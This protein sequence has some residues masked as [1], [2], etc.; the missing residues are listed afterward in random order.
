LT[1]GLRPRLKGQVTAL[2]RPRE[3]SFFVA[4]RALT[5]S[6]STFTGNSAGDGG[7]IYNGNG[8]LTITASTFSGNSAFQG[9]GIANWSGALTVTGST[10][11]GNSANGDGTGGGIENE[12]GTLAI[13]VSTF[14]GNSAGN[15]G[16]GIFN[17]FA[18]LTIAASTVSG[19]S[20]G[21][22]GG[23]IYNFP[24]GGYPPGTV[25]NVRNT[26]L[27][28]NTAKAVGPDVS[29]TLISLG[30]NLIGNGSHGSG[31]ATTDLV[32][33]SANPIDP[34]LGPLQD[35][36]G[37]TWT[38]ALL[39]GSPAIGAGGPGDSEWDQRGPG[40]ARSINGT[41]DIGAYEV[42]P[43]GCG[44]GGLHTPYPRANS[45]VARDSSQ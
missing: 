6:G 5:V 21:S 24:G 42:Q 38:M 44:F 3:S 2:I 28:G 18:T 43:V 26:L 32:G 20:A 45:F 34:E 29:G 16:G 15:D 23:G 1:R 14:S 25:K 31:Y 4:F 10:F 27:A 36:G 40:Y 7:G 33:T 13:T 9:G 35:N 30:H 17:Y 11:S 8:R 22:D 12:Y 39:L 41:T 19:N 37:P